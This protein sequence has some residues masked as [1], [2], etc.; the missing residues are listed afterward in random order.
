MHHNYLH[1]R[2]LNVQKKVFISGLFLVVLTLLMTIVTAENSS[3]ENIPVEEC[4]LICRLGQ[5][6]TG[7]FGEAVAGKA[8]E[9]TPVCGDGNIVA[10]EECDDG[11][12]AN[13]DG[14]SSICLVESDWDCFSINSADG[15]SSECYNLIGW[16]KFEDIFDTHIVPTEISQLINS[17]PKLGWTGNASYLYNSDPILQDLIPSTS[18]F[19]PV[20]VTADGG[21]SGK[22]LS[23]TSNEVAFVRN[24]EV[25]LFLG[26]Y[27]FLDEPSFTLSTWVKTNNPGYLL[28]RMRKGYYIFITD[29]HHVGFSIDT[30]EMGLQTVY[31]IERISNG[32]NQIVGTFDG[33]V[34]NI[35]V[36]G[37]RSMSNAL[38]SLRT[39]STPTTVDYGSLDGPEQYNVLCLNCGGNYLNPVGLAG[40]LDEQR[41][42]AS[43][44][45]RSAVQALFQQESVN[46]CGNA[47]VD[48][49]EV[50]D[51]G[52]FT[53][54]GFIC[55]TATYWD[56]SA[57]NFNGDGC[58]S[59]CIVEPGWICP[60][61]ICT[62]SCG[63]GN[64]E[65]DEQC[66]D[67][68]TCSDGA[69]CSVDRECT[70][71]GDG[72]C[73]FRSGDGC[74]TSCQL[75]D[76]F[77]CN[78]G[79]R[80]SCHPVIC[81]DGDLEVADDFSL[82][83]GCD[84][85]NLVNGDGCSATCNVESG[86]SCSYGNPSVCTSIPG[87]C[88]DGIVAFPEECDDG[89]TCSSGISCCASDDVCVDSS[90]GS[91]CQNTGMRCGGCS[92]DSCQNRDTDRCTNLCKKAI[93]GDGIT[94]LRGED[95]TSGTPDDEQCDDNNLFNDDSCLNTCQLNT[96]GD[97]YRNIAS[98]QCEDG[99]KNNGDGCSSTCQVEP[100]W[101]CSSVG[102]CFAL[103]CGDGIIAGA[104]ECD[105]G[106]QR[107]NDG[108]SMSLIPEEQCQIESGW[109]CSGA[110]SGSCRSICGDGIISIT[111][112]C[113]DNNYF[114]GDGCSSSCFIERAWSCSGLPSI[115]T[116]LCGNGQ[117]DSIMGVW[118]QCDDGNTAN[119]DGC[120]SS[121]T[122]ELGWLCD[123]MPSI[124]SF[125]G[126]GLIEADEECDDGNNNNDDACTNYCQSFICGDGYV[127]DLFEECD[128]GKQCA[129]G[130][131]SCTQDSQ[132]ST[133][134]GDQL[135]QVRNGDG[136]Y[137]YCALEHDLVSWWEF[138]G[139]VLD[140]EGP[141]DRGEVYKR[142]TTIEY[143]SGVPILYDSVSYNPN[144]LFGSALNLP[145]TT[146]GS[147]SYYNYFRLPSNSI[148]QQPQLTW[149]IFFKTNTI[150][151]PAADQYLIGLGDIT[152][153]KGYSVYLDGSGLPRFRL[154]DY[155]T[156]T[157]QNKVIGPTSGNDLRDGGWHHLASTYDG[158]TM[159]LYSDGQE[160][161]SGTKVVSGIPYN[162]WQ[163]NF[164]ADSFD[165]NVYL[166]FEGSIDEVKLYDYALS[167]LDIMS[168]YGEAVVHVCGNGALDFREECDDGNTLSG[169]GC[170]ARTCQIEAGWSCSGSP[171][172]C[173]SDTSMCGNGIVDSAV[174]EECDYAVSNLGYY[175]STSCVITGY[176]GDTILQSEVG[177]TCDD[178]NYNNADACTNSCVW[179]DTD[180]DGIK[181]SGDGNFVL[182]DSLCSSSLLTTCDDNCLTIS[183]PTQINSD[184]DP[185]G[186]ACDNCPTSVNADQQDRDRDSV[187][188]VC[189]NCGDNYNQDQSDQDGDGIGD[190]CDNC[191]SVSN[192]N[193][194]DTDGDGVGDVCEV[195]DSDGDSIPDGMD[196][197]PSVSNYDQKNID[198]ITEDLLGNPRLGDVCD[199]DA[200][201]DGICSNCVNNRGQ[202]TCAMNNWVITLESCIP[203]GNLETDCVILDNSV[204]DIEGDKYDNCRYVKNAAPSLLTC[205]DHNGDGIPDD[206][207]QINS[208]RD[209]EIIPYASRLYDAGFILPGDACDTDDDGDG[210]LDDGDGRG[211]I[212]DHY[213]SETLTVGCDDNCRTTAN[214]DQV[215]SDGNGI[216][217]VCENCL[218]PDFD[219]I[220]NPADNCPL[221]ANTNQLNN[222]EYINAIFN[223]N[224]LVPYDSQIGDEIIEPTPPKQI[225]LDTQGD[226]C[227][228][229]D[230]ND[231]I[232]DDGDGSGTIGD[233][234]C[235]SQTSTA[236][237]D[238][239]CQ[240]MPNTQKDTDHDGFGDKCDKD[241]DGDDFCDLDTTYF[242]FINDL[243]SRHLMPLQSCTGVDN[244]EDISNPDQAYHD[245][246]NLGDACDVDDDNDGI[247]D[248]GQTGASCGG[249]DNC[250]LIVNLDQADIDGDGIG[251]ACDLCTD[252][253]T[254]GYGNPEYSNTCLLDNCPSV[255]NGLDQAAI[256]GVGN[257]LN[258]DGDTLG[259]ACDTCP[260]DPLNDIDGDG[261]CGNVDNCPSSANP[262][263]TDTDRDM[264]GDA[265]DVQDCGNRFI[266][267]TETCDDGC[268]SDRFCDSSDNGD[269]CSSICGI[270]DQDS[271]GV[272]DP[273]DNCL[274]TPNPT[275]ENFQTFA[276]GSK[277][278]A[279]GLFYRPRGVAVD[280]L[281]NVYI[282]DSNNR[283]VQKFT[284]DGVFITKWGT[285]GAGDGQFNN[286]I[287]IAVDS[288]NNIYVADSGNYRVQ[289]FTSD[290]LFITK[291]GTNGAGDGQFNQPNGVA[292]DSL[293]HVYVT[294]S[295]NNRVQKFDSNGLFMSKFSGT[296]FFHG[297]AVDS[298]DGI[299]SN[300]LV[301]VA[302]GSDNSIYIYDFAG[303]FVNKLGSTGLGDGEFNL[304]TGGWVYS[305]S[306]VAVD[307]DGN[308]YVAD[309]NN[310]RVQKLDP[311]GQFI[312]KWGSYGAN[313]GQFNKSEGIV[314]SSNKVY[315]ID[316][317]NHRVQYFV[318]DGDS[319]G[320]ACDNCPT[321]SNDDQADKDG[322]G[323][324][325][326]CDD[327]DGDTFV[328][329]TD[330]CLLTPNP[331]QAD[332]DGDGV[333]D[334]CDDTDGDGVMDNIDNCVLISNSGQEDIDGDGK[335]NACD[336]PECSNR[337]IE[338]PEQCDDGNINNND[339]CSAPGATSLTSCQ[340][341][342]GYSCSG[343]PSV[344]ITGC[345][346][347]VKS[348]AE[349]C[350]DNNLLD[351]DGC[352]AQCVSEV[353]GN[354]KIQ[355]HE[356]CDN[357][358]EVPDDG[359]S[360]SCTL[361]CTE[362]GSDCDKDGY[363]LM[364][365][366]E[367]YDCANNVDTGSCLGVSE[368]TGSTVSCNSCIHPN[369]NILGI[370][371]DGTPI[372]DICG[373]G[374]DQ[375]CDT[376]DCLDADGDRFYPQGAGSLI[377]TDPDCNDNDANIN[378][379]AVEI[380]NGV[381]DDCDRIVDEE[382]NTYYLDY[383]RDG[384]GNNEVTESKCSASIDYVSDNT[385]CDDTNNLLFPGQKWY[386]DS[387]GDGFGNPAVELV[388]CTQPTGYVL[389]NTDCDD[390]N[391]L[392]F[393][394]QKWYDDS[395]G[396]GFGN[397]LAEQISC[398]QLEG[399]VLAST[400][401]DDSSADVKPSA[402]D[403]CDATN[404]VI[405]RNCNAADDSDLDCT[406]LCGDHDG[407]G[408]VPTGF[409]SDSVFCVF[410]FL[411]EGDCNDNDAEMY[412]G[413]IET[414]DTKD[415]NCY[416]GVDDGLTV[417]TGTD[418][419]ECQQGITVCQGTDG[420]VNTQVEVL[421]T[422]EICDGLDNDCDGADDG[423]DE[424]W[425]NQETIC[426]VGVCGTTGSYVCSDGVKMDTC[427]PLEAG[428]EGLDVDGA[429][430]LG[431]CSDDLDNDCDTFTDVLDIIS[432]DID[433]DSIVNEFDNCPS[434]ANSQDL[435]SDGVLENGPDTDNDRIGDVCDNCVDDANPG[436]E[437]ANGDGVG[438]VC[439]CVPNGDLITISDFGNR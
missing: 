141:N 431:T 54:S 64:L 330:N 388:S 239:N 183:N 207:N 128:N 148:L 116:T 71:I 84:D 359:C 174:G 283:R 140:S 133:Q 275:Q 203:Q 309:S 393:P 218:D 410:R 377:E 33:Y 187:G 366:G 383:D 432:C 158:S 67:G 224:P 29:D 273:S 48:A 124:C 418:A 430:L 290:G 220:C 390:T 411:E 398:T 119:R 304:E 413:N 438:D 235:I 362:S 407:D 56:G 392:L 156:R 382:G 395:D 355:I 169:D 344:C 104:E 159:K 181:D 81:G 221:N 209:L 356:Q 144:G 172:V 236:G 351:G 106:N 301:Y 367:S 254:D 412:P 214:I 136:C 387:D 47:Q 401:C 36:N 18:T 404:N 394:G 13:G 138:E 2:E 328:D 196:N 117:M 85:R 325:D 3:G 270:E 34:M 182:G 213:C 62:D 23:S 435:N 439:E 43:A 227:D 129:D 298:S 347:G 400:D 256:L 350:D 295:R 167:Y 345:G 370:T 310:N 361:V 132:C 171:L 216:G 375:N 364:V 339:G 147:S 293:D 164:G 305:F 7:L 21:V 59:T 360:L 50:C 31:S 316:Y 91:Y 157:G 312:T 58:S 314:V 94:Q 391:N 306:G 378:P 66:D 51:N 379:E 200:D 110:G 389:D 143:G 179:Q 358:A 178:G 289:K 405:N 102:A 251:D 16:W 41:I 96:C 315:V 385:D 150:P 8:V 311:H 127:Y 416:D 255:A 4:N 45:S 371:E 368:C 103:L 282:T 343:S 335:G 262:L 69:F 86:W 369:S 425:F 260:L 87:G 14:C 24:I 112:D 277:G 353:C 28:S 426:G 125:C 193:Q 333:G 194:L 225:I 107:S 373:D 126:N 228:P 386:D 134:T 163:V 184:S 327:S 68:K 118:E 99:N 40:E 420:M 421:P 170:S 246:D 357:G 165:D 229:D 376:H 212:G 98:E 130:I 348:A 122:T 403:I 247:C 384:F 286:P 82:L 139:S 109:T 32:W 281:G 100:G 145:I 265:C 243:T 245:T 9:S 27:T 161:A 223:S 292:V 323:I 302:D 88:G 11:N 206:C 397:N 114:S 409:T 1:Q 153:S 276:F 55:T 346:N 105:D 272:I 238:D 294:D 176:C 422:D 287:G 19:P 90:F 188:D 199:R 191:L 44:L 185:L 271:D 257:Q 201:A 101:Y 341:E 142:L 61:N 318:L 198:I 25:D 299:D 417:T 151:L 363:A 120:S 319:L 300:D 73:L 434:V 240:Y 30:V 427:T 234:K 72:T 342:D 202:C 131:T 177:E 135:C 78:S 175:C 429:L 406:D 261:R 113:D 408:F 146:E 57:C 320:N 303:N 329:A 296:G 79:S 424:D 42:Y 354:G 39:S 92:L 211:I 267:G 37:E 173:T 77:N 192:L 89:L 5:W 6:W 349:E 372:V 326:M 331:N 241:D 338:E 274:T 74:S 204:T 285:S 423:A 80:T 168:I 365:D 63:N 313:I 419:G 15:L 17:R 288:S 244:C 222:E 166:F 433:G 20:P 414:C 266:E 93:C 180:T 52:G 53:S 399:Y 332:A 264:M 205:V 195:L 108:C 307:T 336:N 321:V 253:D 152:Q 155:Q 217:D 280:S 258:T 83:E 137:S 268:G 380:C 121:C 396:D 219:T 374:I 197:C 263:Q 208:D 26:S 97:G 38:S 437:D 352:D 381:D 76:G 230:D 232:L 252:T 436:Q 10:E 22:K 284:S 340:I 46:L 115:C 322:D 334:V 324:G 12:T 415:N 231:G 65:W 291:W 49:N 111:E 233:N 149:S 297:I 190:R 226:V 259:D 60:N 242:L 250:P 269:G 210:I 249:S 160:V 95:G 248:P 215:D 75:E 428:F 162:N 278:T 237:C 189:D 186:D 123:G 154:G 279:N 402:S 35:Y 317:Y 70:G 308:I 337:V